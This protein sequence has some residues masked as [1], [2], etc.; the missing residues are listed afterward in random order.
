M[1]IRLSPLPTASCY[2]V[3][4]TTHKKD[5]PSPFTLKVSSNGDRNFLFERQPDVVKAPAP[6]AELSVSHALRTSSEILLQ[7]KAYV[8][9]QAYEGGW[10]DG[11]YH[12]E[13]SFF[14]ADGQAYVGQWQEGQKHGHGTLRTADGDLFRGIWANGQTEQLWP[15][16]SPQFVAYTE[17]VFHS[18][19]VNG[20][21]RASVRELRDLLAS[22]GLHSRLGSAI[23][24]MRAFD[25]N[26]DGY[27]SVT[28]FTEL[29]RQLCEHEF[30]MREAE[31][32][33]AGFCPSPPKPAAKKAGK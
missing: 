7:S 29:V 8:T 12:G 32:A 4:P 20:D 13:G 23:Q 26:A 19:D 3:V 15:I 33:A 5:C 25:E 24:V 16:R 27:L 9:G 30:A 18:A 1:S 31:Q 28:E 10:K 21:G 2:F 11:K 22:L 17:G 6:Q 14:F